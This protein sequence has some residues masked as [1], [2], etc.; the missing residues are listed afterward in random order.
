MSDK[1]ANEVTR[2]LKAINAGDA[3]SSEELLPLVYEE[4]RKLAASH[5]VREKQGHT[6]Q[7]TALVHEAYLRLL[8]GQGTTWNDRGHFFGAAA[9]AMRRILVEQARKRG[10][11]KHGGE[12]Q[13]V[14]LDDVA[15]GNTRDD[16]DFVVLDEALRRMEKEDERMARVVMLRFFAGLSVS[17]TADVMGVSPMTVKRD[18]ACAKAWL[19]DELNPE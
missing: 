18:W 16:V 3:G 13:R 8:G 5:M 4:L 15:D 10:R 7:P 11:I 12:L 19:Y 9:L 6:L 2:L 1:A 14:S 17:D